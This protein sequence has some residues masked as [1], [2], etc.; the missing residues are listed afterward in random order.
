MKLTKH[1]CLLIL[2]LACG[3]VATAMSAQTCQVPQSFQGPGPGGGYW[4]YI[5]NGAP[6]N[7]ACWNLNGNVQVLHVNDCGY[8]HDADNTFDMH[9]GARLSQEFTVPAGNTATHWDLNYLLTMQDPNNDGWWNRLKV[10]VYDYTTGRNLASQTYW[11]DDPDVSCTRRDLTFTGNLAGHRLL[12]TFS[13][14]SA[15]ANTV[16]HVR[17]ISLMQYY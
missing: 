13:D 16:F 5:A 7:S 17:S 15:Y 3:L 1:Y 4:E 9:Y 11:G 6:A 14:G 10:T 8:L 2:I 12:V